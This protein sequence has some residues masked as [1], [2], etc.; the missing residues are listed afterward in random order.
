MRASDLKKALA[1]VS[2]DPEIVVRALLADGRE[3]DFVVSLISF[4]IGG[5]PELFRLTV[6][7]PELE[8]T[9]GF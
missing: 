7:E 6:E 8:A 2:G 4:E 9:P 5:G 3:I 1:D